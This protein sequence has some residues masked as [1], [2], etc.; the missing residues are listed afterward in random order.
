MSNTWYEVVD[1]EGG[2]ILNRIDI[3]PTCWPNHT[4][5]TR[6]VGLSARVKVKELATKPTYAI[7]HYCGREGEAA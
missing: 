5:T 6:K 2:R 1:R 4:E 3:C 7:C